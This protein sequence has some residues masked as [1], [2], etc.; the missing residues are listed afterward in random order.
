MIPEKDLK[1]ELSSSLPCLPPRTGQLPEALGGGP[2]LWLCPPLP[3]WAQVSQ[4]SLAQHP[5]GPE[6]TPRS[7]K[8]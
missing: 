4:P 2:G 6:G 8:P 7:L 3:G 1:P 5:P